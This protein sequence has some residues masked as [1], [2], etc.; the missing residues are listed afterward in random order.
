M[1]EGTPPGDHLRP[2]AGPEVGVLYNYNYDSVVRE[3]KS[4]AS[5]GSIGFI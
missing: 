2:R 1:A 4:F 3:G 5:K